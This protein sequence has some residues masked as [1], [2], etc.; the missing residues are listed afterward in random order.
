MELG[1]PPPKIPHVPQLPPS[2][3]VYEYPYVHVGY[4]EPALVAVDEFKYPTLVAYT[5]AVADDP[6][7]NPLT[8]MVPDVRA[9][10]PEF[11]LIT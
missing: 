6:L 2:V 8:V 5:D 7:V 4:A 3:V 1:C 9:I 11:V 10:L